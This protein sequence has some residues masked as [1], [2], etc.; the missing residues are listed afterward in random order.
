MTWKSLHVTGKIYQIFR[1]LLIYICAYSW[2]QVPIQWKDPNSQPSIIL[3]N[4][5]PFMG[6]VM[7]IQKDNRDEGEFTDEM[8]NIY[9]QWAEFELFWGIQY[10]KI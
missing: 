7:C 4:F 6:V 2:S 3:Y 8:T 10:V 5:S 1:K 9:R